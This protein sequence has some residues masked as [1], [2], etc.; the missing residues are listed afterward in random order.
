MLSEIISINTKFS[1]FYEKYANEPLLKPLVTFS[2]RKKIYTIQ[3]LDL[4][5][6]VDPEKFQL[7]TEDRG[8]PDIAHFDARK[9]L[10]FPDVGIQKWFQMDIK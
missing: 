4:R 10:Y 7:L 3:V 8:E 1:I 6:Q 2:D 9:V 5:F